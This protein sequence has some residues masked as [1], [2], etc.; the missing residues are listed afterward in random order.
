MAFIVK[1]RVV[2]VDHVPNCSKS[3]GCSEACVRVTDGW[4]ADYHLRLP[5]ADLPLRKRE[6][7]PHEWS[8]TKTSRQ[9]WAQQRE[10][11]YLRQTIEEVKGKSNLT[12]NELIEKFI[13]QREA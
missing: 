4:V 1:E 7:I 8:A 6:R 2:R 9:D 12:V 3:R 5:G 11:Y 10:V 13:A